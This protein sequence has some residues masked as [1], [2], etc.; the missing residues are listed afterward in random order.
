MS[1]EIEST[2]LTAKTLTTLLKANSNPHM[3]IGGGNTHICRIRTLTD[4][5]LM[6][7]EVERPDTICPECGAVVGGRAACQKL[8]DE[9][10]AR[11]F[12]D[13]RYARE[14]RLTVDVYSLQH[15][16]EY[17]RSAKS[18]AAH[19]TGM[20]AALEDDTTAAANR[21]VQQWLSGPK[22][23]TRPDHPPP[24]Q[25]G[26]LTVTHVHEANDPDEHVRRVREWAESTWAAWRGYHKVAKEWIVEARKFLV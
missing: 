21:A 14:H 23:L 12:G 25:R 1:L 7:A 15:P 10:L 24:R 26:T 4:R 13:Y 3:Q 17:M 16:A 8:F 20:Y 2:R 22:A 5:T 19:L 18:Y 6:T 11:E 9:I